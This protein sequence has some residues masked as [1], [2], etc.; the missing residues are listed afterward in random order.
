MPKLSLTSGYTFTRSLSIPLNYDK[1]DVYAGFKYQYFD[2]CFLFGQYGETWQFFDTLGKGRYPFWDAGI[3]HDTDIVKATLETNVQIT[4]DPL[5]VSTKLTSY[6][7]KLDKTLQ[8][9]ALG[10]SCTYAEYANTETDIRTQRK[11][12]F[13]GSGRYEIIPDLSASLAATAER[14]YITAASSYPYHFIASSGLEYNLNHDI[15]FTLTYSF[16]TYRY[17]V[18]SGPVLK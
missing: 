5:S 6:I 9:G 8:R 1:H 2:K 15:T 7:G 12:S 14:Y 17:S 16:E 18:D 11:L 3:T 10:L 4:P 13:G